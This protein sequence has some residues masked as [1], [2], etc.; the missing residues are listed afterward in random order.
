MASATASSRSESELKP[1]VSVLKLAVHHR[2]PLARRQRVGPADVARGP[3][4]VLRQRDYPDHWDSLNSWL[5]EHGLRP[6]IAGEYDGI[7]SL[8]TAVEAGLGMAVVT[9]GTTQLFPKRAHFK[10]F[11]AAPQALGVVAGYRLSRGADKSLAAFVEEL[12]KAAQA[13]G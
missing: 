9:A 7:E 5:H 10:A 2:H 8:M 6:V 12:R 4:L 11:S 3:L 13:C 1:R